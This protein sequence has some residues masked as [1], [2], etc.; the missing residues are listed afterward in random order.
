MIFIHLMNK[1][2]S[3]S[4]SGSLSSRTGSPRRYCCRLTS[5]PLPYSKS[6]GF[7][8]FPAHTDVTFMLECAFHLALLFKKNSFIFLFFHY[9]LTL[10]IILFQVYSIVVR[11]LYN[12]QS[13]PP[14]NSRTHLA[15][16]TVIKILLTIFSMAHFT[17][18]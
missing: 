17:S 3:N 13:D 1:T 6:H 14:S 10:S 18:P 11:Q 9:S 16:H 2:F 7:P 4:F 8:G 12:L 15:P 5:R